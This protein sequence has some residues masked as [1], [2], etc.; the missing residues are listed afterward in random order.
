MENNAP[1]MAFTGEYRKSIKKPKKRYF[2]SMHQQAFIQWARLAPLIYNGKRDGFI[3]D[4]LIANANGGARSKIEGARLKKEGVTPG[5]SD[6]FFAYPTKTYHGLWIEFKTEE[7]H[8]LLT[9]NQQQWLANMQRLN[10][11]IA[12]PR[13]LQQ[14]IDMIEIYL[15][16]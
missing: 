14:A 7:K 12:V 10:Y 6:L 8:S 9:E 2:E 16:T 13:N 5:V 11:Q 15:L 1:K 3:K 4:C